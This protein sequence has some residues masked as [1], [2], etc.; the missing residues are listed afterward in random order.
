MLGLTILIF[1]MNIYLGNLVYE[2]GI[3]FF[4]IIYFICIMVSYKETLK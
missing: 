1:L 3:I 2:F 4:G